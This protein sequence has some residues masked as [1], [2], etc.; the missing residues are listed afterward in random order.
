MV[1]LKQIRLRDAGTLFPAPACFQA[2]LTVA[3]LDAGSLQSFEWGV[4]DDVGFVLRGLGALVLSFLALPSF[5]SLGLT[6]PLGPVSFLTV[7]QW[8]SQQPGASDERYQ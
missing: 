1:C 2:G 7:R 6:G 5:F 3:L 4:E 8:S